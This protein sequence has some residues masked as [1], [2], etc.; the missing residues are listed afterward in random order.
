MSTYGD[1][2][3]KSI[4]RSVLPSTARKSAR[5]NKRNFHKK[6]R[7]A[8]REAIHG[9]R[10]HLV[11]VDEAGRLAHDPD[12]YDDFE[13]REIFDGYTAATT[14]PVGYDGNMK[15]IVQRRRDADKLGPLIAWATATEKNK[16]DGWD[17][18]D[19]IAYFKAVLPDTLQGR[20]AL[21][22]VKSALRL[23]DDEFRYGYRRNFNPTTLEDFRNALARCLATKHG[24]KSLRDLLL[25]KVP[26][27]GH[28]IPA[29]NKVRS[30][31]P[32]VDEGGK[33]RFKTVGEGPNRR[34]YR[35]YVD[36]YVPQM[37]SVACD[38]CTFLRTDFLI[39]SDAVKRF[40]EIIWNR[41]KGG[42]H[43]YLVRHRYI[44]RTPHGFDRR[45]IID[46]VLT[47]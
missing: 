45:E 24:R 8:Q 6:H 9:A 35:V 30:H 36:I 31:E 11:V 19:K 38:D 46:H 18:N 40:V 28:K 17:D 2:K 15:Y 3:A 10:Q 37:I 44:D 12:L 13:D 1:K 29:P 39:D 43:P 20:H 41:P 23:S 14:K 27:A 16:M 32:A 25:D 5:D 42:T 22:H 7:A 34:T 33:P 21:G 4:A 47:F 26:V